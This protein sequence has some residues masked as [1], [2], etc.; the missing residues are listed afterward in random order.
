MTPRPSDPSQP[1]R[2]LF[3][4]T[5]NTCRSPTAEALA[6][7]ELEALGWENIEVESAGIATA[8]GMPASEGARRAAQRHELDLSGHR[9][10][11]LTSEVVDRAD[12]ILT[13]SGAHL[14][15]V[16]ELGGKGAAW[17]LSSFAEDEPAEAPDIPDPFGGDDARYEQTFTALERLVSGSIRRLEPMVSS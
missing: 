5:G 13:M 8:P 1:L 12:V 2:V 11:L 7:R 9:S 3:V 10:R 17:K 16:E 14:A 6:R 4:C 15:R